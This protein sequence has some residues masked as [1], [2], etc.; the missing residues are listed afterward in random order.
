LERHPESE[1][2]GLPELR[3]ACAAFAQE[4]G[5]RFW[6]LE[7]EHP[8]DD[9]G[10]A[11][12]A[13]LT[14]MRKE[15]RE[16]QG[17]LIDCFTQVNPVAVRLSRLAPLWL[18]FGCQDSLDFLRGMVSQLPRE[19]PVLFAPVPSFAG[20]FDTVVLTDW[21]AA[22]AGFDVHCPGLN[23]RH[24]PAHLGVL[25]RFAPALRAWC[26]AHP[27]PLRSHLTP[28]ELN[29]LAGELATFPT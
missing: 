16:P 12:H 19:K 23:V 9:A 10:L 28:D 27:V 6:A 14:L 29:R 18:P 21:L 26:A 11:F 5:Y 20:T 1:W 3:H 25:V 17:T 2:G 13:Q 22:L 4:N 8:A 7:G 24:Y 15:G